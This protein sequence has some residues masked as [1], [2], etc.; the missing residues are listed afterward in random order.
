[1]PFNEYKM[2]NNKWSD[3]NTSESDTHS[4]KESDVGS[5]SE[6]EGHPTFD[7]T[8]ADEILRTAP[9]PWLDPLVR[10]PILPSFP[11]RWLNNKN[12]GVKSLKRVFA[13]NDGTLNSQPPPMIDPNY[14]QIDMSYIS[15]LPQEPA[16]L[17]SFTYARS[18]MPNIFSFKRNSTTDVF[19]TNAAPARRIPSMP[20]NP[21]SAS[22]P[23]L[24]NPIEHQQSLELPT[25]ISSLA[26]L[27]H[28]EDN[29][30]KVGARI[31]GKD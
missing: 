17:M 28:F 6:T 7:T 20:P 30:E 22:S 26:P 12:F 1:M 14:H 9:V 21:S 27:V 29:K 25:L 4:D 5:D 13:S 16:D 8:E 18:S 31:S 3:S 11:S 15:S 23:Y 10:S 19:N 2:T 24:I